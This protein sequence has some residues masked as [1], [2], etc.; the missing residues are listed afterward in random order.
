VRVDQ[1][2]LVQP[3]YRLREGIV[4]SRQLRSIQSLVSELFG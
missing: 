3:I 1:L 4:Q 2:G